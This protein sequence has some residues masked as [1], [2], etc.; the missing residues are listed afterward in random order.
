MNMH[1]MIRL[2]PTAR[3]EIW[4]LYGTG[5]WTIVALA[6]EFRV[7]R[8]TVYKVIHRARSHEFAPRKSTNKRFLQSKAACPRE[9]GG[10]ET[11]GKD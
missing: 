11:S 9:G 6:Q 4:R 10:N 3:K 1:K 8:P 7:S 5:E 2:T